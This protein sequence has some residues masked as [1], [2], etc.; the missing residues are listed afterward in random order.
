TTL[1]TI[2]IQSSSNFDRLRSI[3]TPII[4][5]EDGKRGKFTFNP[6][7]PC[8]CNCKNK[9]KQDEEQTLKVTGT[10][11]F[12]GINHCANKTSLRSFKSSSRD[13]CKNST[14][15]GMKIMLFCRRRSL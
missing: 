2:N 9:E 4:R 11:S 10:D 13:Q 5:F 1:V 15:R 8:C 12:G 3:R 14:I 6:N 7:I